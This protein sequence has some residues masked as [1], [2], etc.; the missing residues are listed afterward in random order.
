MAART[1]PHDKASEGSANTACP[2]DEPLL[3]AEEIEEKPWK[4]IGYRGYSEFIASENDF[5]ILRGF[6]SLNTCVALAHQDQITVLEERLK[7]LDIEYG[8]RDAEDRHNGSFRSDRDDRTELVDLI[9][10]KLLIYSES[11]RC[12]IQDHVMLTF[13]KDNLLIQQSTL[14]KY[15]PVY[16]QDL[17][18]VRNWHYNYDNRVIADEE[19]DYLNHDQDLIPVV[20][21]EK[22]PLRR[23][24]ER[25]RK[26][27]IFRFWQLDRESLPIH[28]QE[29]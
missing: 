12:N 8:R 5:Y 1:E 20:P 11:S 14:R 18:S 16:R 3:T 10:E 9:A 24:L 23:F 22:T 27:R 19:A 29:H 21:K 2:P 15:Q 25:S 28:D 26:F 4:Y 17:K 7:T 13:L 6:R